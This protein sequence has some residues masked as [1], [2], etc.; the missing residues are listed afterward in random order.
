[1]PRRNMPFRVN[2]VSVHRRFIQAIAEIPL[3]QFSIAP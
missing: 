1:M 3:S 2:E